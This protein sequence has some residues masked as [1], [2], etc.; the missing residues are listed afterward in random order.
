MKGDYVPTEHWIPKSDLSIQDDSLF[1]ADAL[2][3]IDKITDWFK[4]KRTDLSI[5]CL[6]DCV[7]AKKK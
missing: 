1:E 6:R 4:E 2:N 3:D 7:P 5:S